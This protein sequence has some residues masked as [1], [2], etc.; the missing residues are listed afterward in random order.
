MCLKVFSWLMS[1]RW[2]SLGQLGGCL[3]W[4]AAGRPYFHWVSWLWELSPVTSA[5]EC[6]LCQYFLFAF[7]P[8]IIGALGINKYSSDSSNVA[9]LSFFSQTFALC[10]P[11]MHYVWVLPCSWRALWVRGVIFLSG[12]I[13]WTIC[14]VF[15]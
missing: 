7:S 8:G 2:G 6:F 10:S 4:Q 15:H 12:I 5:I 3:F 9:P 14:Y 13:Y 1:E 11:L